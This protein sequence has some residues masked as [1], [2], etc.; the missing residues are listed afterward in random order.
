[1]TR[2]TKIDGGGLLYYD[3]SDEAITVKHLSREGSCLLASESTACLVS[4][5]RE[6]NP[7][8]QLSQNLILKLL[9]SAF[10]GSNV[11]VEGST[12]KASCPLV[13]GQTNPLFLWEFNLSLCPDMVEEVINPLLNTAMMLIQQKDTLVS[14]VKKKDLEIAEYRSLGISLSRKSKPSAPYDHIKTFQKLNEP[15]R[16]TGEI[17]SNKAFIEAMEHSSKCCRINQTYVSPSKRRRVALPVGITFDDSLSQLN[18]PPPDLLSDTKSE[19]SESNHEEHVVSA[20]K[21]ETVSIPD[22]VLPSGKMNKR[23]KA[24]RL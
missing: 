21:V 16:Q 2:W 6:F 17:L 23:K 4:K 10:E 19:E 5:C 24:R 12:M 13:P 11:K 22:N 15:I 18:P 14:L 1:M 20:L 8:L 3:I 7:Q 9:S